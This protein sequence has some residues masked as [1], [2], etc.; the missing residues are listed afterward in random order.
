MGIF[1]LVIYDWADKRFLFY[2]FPFGACFL[3]EGLSRLFV[4]ARGSDLR[5]I[6]ASA[7]LSVALL[8]NQIHYPT[9]G[10]QYVALTPRD[11][12]DAIGRTK[13]VPVARLHDRWVSAFTDGLFDYRL[14]PADCRL[15]GDYTG[16]LRL[17]PLLDEMLGRGVAIGLHAPAGWPADYWSCVNRASNIL[18]RPVV[19]PDLA[20]CSLAGQEVPGT[21]T[22]LSVFPYFVV[23]SS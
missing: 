14:L 7:Y 23:C 13:G 1:F 16:L 3:A 11:F 6:A 10:I 21:R 4:W 9:H 22:L 8:W 15:E 5:L 17:R 19:R 18:E 12:F 20:P 2:L